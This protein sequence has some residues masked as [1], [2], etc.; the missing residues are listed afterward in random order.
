MK[1]FIFI[2][3]LFQGMNTKIIFDFNKESNLQVWIIVDDAVMGGKST[4]EIKLN[5]N[6]FGVFKGQ[7]SVANN[8]GFSSV[9]YQFNK[10]NVAKYS[11]IRIRLKGDG[12][13]Y[14]FRIKDNAD[15]YYSYIATF[16]TANTWENIEIGLKNMYPSLRGRKLDIPNFSHN[17]IEQIAFLIAN[18]KDENFELLIDT[19]E[20]I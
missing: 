12:K 2:L 18:K 13:D 19:I 11:K 5:A 6:G 17:Y 1:Y 7:V 16:S 20:L 15:S 4:S 8:G 9:R 3:I 14:Q 10:L